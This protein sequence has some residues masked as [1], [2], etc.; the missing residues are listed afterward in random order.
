MLSRLTAALGPDASSPL[1]VALRDWSLDAWSGGGYSD[2]IVDMDATDA[3]ATLIVGCP[4][5]HFAS[6]ELSPSFPGYVEGAIVAGR[7][8][9]RRVAMNLRDQSA[10][11][12]SA[13]GS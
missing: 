6:S 13:S 4:P 1:D 12:T 8:A 2:L 3:E 5:V 11:A 7:L 9:A 10:I